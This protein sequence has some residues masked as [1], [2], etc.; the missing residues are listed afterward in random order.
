MKDAGAKAPAAGVLVV[1]YGNALRGDDG[2]G[3]RAAERIATD[4]RLRGAEILALHQL[5]PEVAADM[6]DASLVVLVDARA[7]DEPGA[8]TV[9]R[10]DASCEPTSAPSHH[11]EPAALAG[12]ARELWGATPEV[13]AVT[14]GAASFDGGE[15]LSPAVERALP[16]VVDAVAAIVADHRHA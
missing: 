3:P 15:H 14:V 6:R 16:G 8:I 9:R 10:V 7:G 1:G 13:C 2:L 5:T 12:L 4:P 11:V